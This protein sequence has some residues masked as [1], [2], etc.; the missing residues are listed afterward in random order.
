MGQFEHKFT[1][2]L[3]HLSKLFR[4]G[5]PFRE[6]VRRISGKTLQKVVKIL[7][8]FIVK[9]LLDLLIQLRCEFTVGN[10]NVNK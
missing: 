7:F 3:N 4:L 9:S 10:K 2:Q 1:R 5:F 8:S 6:A